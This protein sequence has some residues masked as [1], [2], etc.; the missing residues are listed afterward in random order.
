[1]QAISADLTGHGGRLDEAAR[2]YP[3]APA[4]WL[5]LSTGINPNAWA[6]AAPLD[7]DPRA[8]PSRGALRDL[9]V[10]AARHFGVDPAHVAAV[11]GSEIALRLL[12]MLGLPPVA[13][14][15]TT[16]ATHRDV[17]VHRLDA[18]V[19][20]AGATLLLANP[21]NPD[22]VLLSP[23]M[24][25]D[26]ARRQEENGGSLVMDEA[27]AD[28]APGSSLLP[29]LKASDETIVL[30]SFGKFFGL[31]GIR[32]GFVIASGDVIAR[33]RRLLGDWPVS[34][35]AIAFGRAAYADADWIAATATS[36]PVRA[37]ALD[38]LLARHGLAARGA[39]PLFRLIETPHAA[40]LFDRLARAAILVR[41]F[42]DR[43][44]WLRFG[45]P[46]D[47]AAFARLDRALGHG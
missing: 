24:L 5:D 30:R 42:T 41:P 28:A 38:A 25:I 29:H 2:L 6:P 36:L 12:P 20:V 46:A 1:M 11:P 19:P 33:L 27:F 17:A 13:S 15:A 7:I 3:H 44:D 32:L 31:A 4:P 22:G 43:P 39:C 21:N 23:D 9:E 37:A 16:Y 10:I 18:P 40:A 47:E 8:L 45:L 35:H 26:L 14:L 34:A